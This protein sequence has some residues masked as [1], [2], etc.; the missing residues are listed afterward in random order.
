MT[1]SPLRSPS[2]YDTVDLCILASRQRVG[3]AKEQACAAK[4][5]S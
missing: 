2:A 3:K 5:S 1:E 4:L